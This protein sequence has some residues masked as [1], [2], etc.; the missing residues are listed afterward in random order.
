[1]GSP[2]SSIHK[3]V[4]ELSSAPEVFIDRGAAFEGSW[5]LA[6]PQPSD[7]RSPRYCK[8]GAPKPKP[9]HSSRSL[10]HIQR[11]SM[12]GSPLKNVEDMIPCPF[13]PSLLCFL[14]VRAECKTAQ[15]LPHLIEK[16]LNC[17]TMPAMMST[18]C[19]TPTHIRLTR[20]KSVHR[21][22]R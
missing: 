3:A 14:K 6:N 21:Q 11:H 12:Q 7:R 20:C 17:Q 19:E 1:M 4:W 5:T 10:G 8:A 13:Q 15:Y 9:R 18:Q 16:A 2:K 22:R